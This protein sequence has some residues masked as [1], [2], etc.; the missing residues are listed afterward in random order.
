[1]I[2]F[3]DRMNIV[4]AALQMPHYL[5]FSEGVIAF[6]A[7]I[8]FFGYFLL[9]IPGALIVERWSARRWIAR[10]MISWGLMT[11]LMA[12][13]QTP[14]QFYSVRFLVGAAEAGFLPGVIVYLTHWFRYEDRAKAVAFFYAANPLS[15]VIGSPLAGLLLGLS[16]LGLRGWRWL[17]I[18]EGIPAVVLGMITIWYLTDRPEEAEWLPSDEKA[19]L[20]TELLR[21]KEAKKRRRSYSVWQAFRHRD[22]VLLTIC[23]FCAMTGS[24]GIAFWL[25][26]I[27]KRLSGKS[28]L[29]VT[30]L[31]ALPYVA[32]FITQQV[33]SW[34]SDRTRE[35]RWHAAV[36]VFACAVALA[37]AVVYRSNLAVS[38][39]FFVLAGGS[40]YGFQ[41]VFWTV[42]T[43]FLSES[44]AAASIGLINAV[45]N[46]GGFVGPMVMGYLANRT[47]SFSPGLLYLVASL[48]L[49]GV[50]M[51]AVGRQAG[52]GKGIAN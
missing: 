5:V 44:A 24:Y 46:L 2:A 20:T 47:H 49:S 17:F 34:H 13:I 37:L 38:L 4:A 43:L 26:T 23:Y 36:P 40:F 32:A 48:F 28:D 21:E 18:I 45:G 3:L 10:I 1:V 9:E 41:P 29:T 42:P 6:G 25:P 7:G 19:W 12:F 51:L 27:L 50:L 30:L 22:V 16:W 33:N 31:A 14:R 8:F 15:Y 39:G 52:V 35:R 11:V